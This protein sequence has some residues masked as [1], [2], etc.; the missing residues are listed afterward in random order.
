MSHAIDRTIWT[1]F[2]NTFGYRSSILKRKQNTHEGI[3]W[4]SFCPSISH[5]HLR[6]FKLKLLDAYLDQMSGTW[7]AYK[8]EEKKLATLNPC[9]LWISHLT[10]EN[11]ANCGEVFFGN[12]NNIS[13]HCSFCKE[14]EPISC[15]RLVSD[16]DFTYIAS[17]QHIGC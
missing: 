14:L 11:M 2:S 13:H 1:N 9:I 16:K 3:S 6:P 10:L 7:S 17:T 8:F 5:G 4:V 15:T 12:Y